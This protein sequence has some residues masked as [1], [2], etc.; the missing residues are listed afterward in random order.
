[1]KTTE[2]KEAFEFAAVA[3][4]GLGLLGFCTVNI[5]GASETCLGTYTSEV[6]SYSATQVVT[7]DYE[8]GVIPENKYEY[9]YELSLKN[10]DVV[11]V[12]GWEGEKTVKYNIVDVKSA[13]NKH[14]EEYRVVELK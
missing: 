2:R 11:T 6:V 9:E 12:V 1:M 13:F 8:Y 3:A 4:L 7:R 14:T 10:G 5:F